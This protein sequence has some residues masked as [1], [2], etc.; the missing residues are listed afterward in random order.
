MKLCKDCRHYKPAF[1]WGLTIVD[2]SCL[3]PSLMTIDLELGDEIYRQDV[4]TAPRMLR[5]TEAS[6]GVDAKWFELKEFEVKE[7][8]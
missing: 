5:Q 3:H 1:M 4:T 7:V 2:S 6:C 8:R